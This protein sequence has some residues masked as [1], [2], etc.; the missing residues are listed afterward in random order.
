VVEINGDWTPKTTAGARLETSRYRTIRDHSN[1]E[2]IDELLRR[3]YSLTVTKDKP[4]PK[5]DKYLQKEEEKIKLEG[6]I[7]AD[8]R[9]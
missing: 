9:S 3:G 1:I 2:L 6:A 7:Y 8:I 5:M 4:D